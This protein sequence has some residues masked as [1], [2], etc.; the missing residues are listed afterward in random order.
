MPSVEYYREPV[1][2]QRTRYED[3]AAALQGNGFYSTWK[4]RL[5][6]DQPVNVYGSPIGLPQEARCTVYDRRG[7]SIGDA[8]DRLLATHQLNIR[9][10]HH[11]VLHDKPRNFEFEMM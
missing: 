2:G 4:H 7:A 11:D 8:I 9:E 1:K 5:S 3:R 10:L 6:I